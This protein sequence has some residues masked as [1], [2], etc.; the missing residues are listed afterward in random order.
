M[1]GTRQKLLIVDDL[2]TNIK[3][4]MSILNAHSAY[5]IAV[6]TSGQQ[7][8]DIALLEMPD[9]IL[10]DV[11]MPGMDG[12]EVCQ[13]L[14]SDQRTKDIPVIFVSAMDEAEDEAR[15]LEAGGLDYITKPV[16][17]AIVKARVRIHLELKRQ[18]D[19]LRRISMIDGLTGIANRR[20][21]D[22]AL[23]REWRRCQRA[24]TPLSVI[25][26]DVDFFKAYNDHYGHLA[27]DECLKRVAEAMAD[28]MRR[29]TDLAARFG[30]EEFVCLLGDTG[31]EAALAMAQR[32]RAC[33]SEM[34]IPHAWSSV[35]DHVTISLGVGTLVPDEDQDARRL[36]DLADQGLYI[37]KGG[38][39]NRV[40]VV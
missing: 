39:R 15:G 33:V 23:E 22:E 6:A 28:Q 8:L 9:L 5:D 37:A 40:G 32:L 24:A 20:R 14:K 2:I 10:L 18:R 36:V 35:A 30:G 1:N 38:G 34:A 12:Y 3:V 27:G 17:K 13:R 7:A 16:N 19:L 31:T 25:M 26:V 4:L 21:F 11:M 29:G